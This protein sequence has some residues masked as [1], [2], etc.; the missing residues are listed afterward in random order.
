M[1]H[2]TRLLIA[3]AESTDENRLQSKSDQGVLLTCHHIL[4]N[5][6]ISTHVTN[7]SKNVKIMSTGFQPSVKHIYFGRPEYSKDFYHILAS[8]ETGLTISP[9][10]D[11]IKTENTI[12]CIKRTEQRYFSKT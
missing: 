3:F 1:A 8:N 10:C 12:V 9:G 6:S 7:M 11:V 4:K 5:L 2:Q